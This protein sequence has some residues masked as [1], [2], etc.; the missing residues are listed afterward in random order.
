MLLRT[1]WWK[2]IGLYLCLLESIWQ[3][4]LGSCS[5]WQTGAWLQGLVKP[6]GLWHFFWLGL[7]WVRGWTESGTCLVGFYYELFPSAFRCISG[8]TSSVSFV[9]HSKRP[10]LSEVTVSVPSKILFMNIW[11]WLCIHPKCLINCLGSIEI[12]FVVLTVSEYGKTW[13]INV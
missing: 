4:P 7:S 12:H 3:P 9:A 8:F 10:F 13:C 2:L 6:M 5:G 11:I 1:L